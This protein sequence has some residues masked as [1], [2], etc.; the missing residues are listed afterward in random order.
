MD[1]GDCRR[2]EDVLDFF[3]GKLDPALVVNTAVIG[4]LKEP[5][6]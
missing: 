2:P 6:R 4:G 1:E 3:A 5:A